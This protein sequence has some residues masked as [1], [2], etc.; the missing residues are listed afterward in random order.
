MI[1]NVVIEEFQSLT[2]LTAALAFS[3]GQQQIVD[4]VN[5][6]FVL[7]VDQVVS[8]FKLRCELIGLDLGSLA[9]RL[10]L[11][12]RF[13][14]RSFRHHRLC[15]I[16]V[17][18]TCRRSHRPGA[19]AKH[20]VLIVSQ[21]IPAFL[22]E[23]KLTNQLLEHAGLTGE[24]LTGCSGFFRGSRVGLYDTGDLIHTLS[25]LY[26]SIRLLHRGLGNFINGSY[27]AS[28]FFRNSHN[29]LGCF[30]SYTGTI[31]H[32][33]YR[34]LNQCRG[35][36]GSVCRLAGEVAHLIRYNCESTTGCTSTGSF[37]C[38]VERQ[39]I[40]L[41]SNVFDG[42]D[43]LSDLLGLAP[44]LVHGCGHLIH[45]AGTLIQ[46]HTQGIGLLTGLLGVFSIAGYLRR[47]VCNGGCQFLYRA[48]LFCGALAQS[49]CTRRYLIR[50]GSYLVSRL[51]DL[52]HHIAQ[53][54][55]N[56][57]QRIQN[58]GEITDI[59]LR[60]TGFH[61]KVALCHLTEHVILVADD[62]LDGIHKLAYLFSQRAQLVLGLVGDLAAEVAG[63]H[64]GGN[65]FDLL[66]GFNQQADQ[67]Q[68][69][70]HSQY[71]CHSRQSYGKICKLLHI[72]M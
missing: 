22:A 55:L 60:Y 10:S 21:H 11:L 45:L 67:T 23:R 52:H 33:P 41:E 58:S 36:L 44:D 24:L 31:F 37:H 49:L 72:S 71:Q 17:I 29:G 2:D 16:F 66:D 63:C 18:N 69:Q 28:G 32:G 65:A 50:A 27:N 20:G 46:F 35:F 25:N 43:D 47:D 42:L 26:H 19:A 70:Q 68:S 34:I 54:G 12:H 40:G 64:L 62:G 39:N 51:V 4:C 56:V 15:A 48:G 6:L 3:T 30:S 53:T 57:G 59:A 1:G 9:G 7:A 5:Q 13:R 38:R 8:G 61:S 14:V